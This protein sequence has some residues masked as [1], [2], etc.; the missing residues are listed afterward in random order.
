MST[1]QCHEINVMIF[2]AECHE[3]YIV[4][5]K[6]N[7]MTL[8]SWDLE[9][10]MTFIFSG[11]GAWCDRGLKWVLNELIN[12]FNLIGLL[13]LSRVQYTKICGWGEIWVNIGSGNLMAPSHCLNQCSCNQGADSIKRCHLTSIGIPIGQIRQSYDH[14]I[15]TMGFPIL[16][17]W[18]I[19]ILNHGADPLAFNWWQ[20][21]RKWSKISNTKICL[22]ITH[23]KLKPFHFKG[24]WVKIFQLNNIST[25]YLIG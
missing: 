21:H 10:V 20:I 17:R 9:N 6:P 4:G 19:F 7:V 25:E 15:S 16:V 18:K 11:T 5:R 12:Y 8:M 1:R 22:K 23:L 13:P 2:D 14:L 24:Q 3:I